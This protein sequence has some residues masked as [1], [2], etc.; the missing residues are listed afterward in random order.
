MYELPASYNRPWVNN[1]ADEQFMHMRERGGR[2]KRL[3][4]IPSDASTM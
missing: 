4:S 2:L 1:A 3:S